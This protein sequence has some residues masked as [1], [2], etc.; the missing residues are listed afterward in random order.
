MVLPC[1]LYDR[2]LHEMVTKDRNCNLAF[3]FLGC[4]QLQRGLGSLCFS[5]WKHICALSFPRLPRE[6]LT[7]FEDR[8]QVLSYNENSLTEQRKSCIYHASIGHLH[9][10]SYY[11][12]YSV[13]R[14]SF[15][16]PDAFMLLNGKADALLGMQTPW[17]EPSHPLSPS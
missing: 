9:S 14:D 11:G 2:L 8:R 6:L 7:V 13:T 15:E 17:V 4:V 1:T 16:Q 10:Q 12:D 5:L 3:N